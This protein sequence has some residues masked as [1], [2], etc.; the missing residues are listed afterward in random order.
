MKPGIPYDLGNLGSQFTIHD[1]SNREVDA[2]DFVP[3][4]EYLLVFTV[5]ADKSETI[6]IYFKTN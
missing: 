5:R 4:Q 2:V 1:K 6:Q 3:G